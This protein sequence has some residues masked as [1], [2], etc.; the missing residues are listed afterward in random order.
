[1]LTVVF[2]IPSNTRLSG[3][4]FDYWDKHFGGLETLLD[5]AG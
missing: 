1:M 2:A 4:S 5:S 3:H